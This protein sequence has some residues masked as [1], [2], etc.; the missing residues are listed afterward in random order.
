MNS[1]GRL[2]SLSIANGQLPSVSGSPISFGD[3]LFIYNEAAGASLFSSLLGGIGAASQ[4][5]DLVMEPWDYFWNTALIAASGGGVTYESGSGDY[6][7]WLE[8]ADPDD[9]LTFGDV[10]GVRGGKIS[11]QTEGADQVMVVSY[12][13]IVLGNMPPP[14]EAARYEKVAFMGQVPVKVTGRVAIGDYLVPTGNGDGIARAISPDQ[15]SVEDLSRVIGVAWS[16]T[17]WARLTFVKAAVG[18]QTKQ[19]AKVV[20]AQDERIETLEAQ[21]QNVLQRLDE[22]TRLVKGPTPTEN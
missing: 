6:A 4:Q 15:I 18:L 22:V 20:A 3:P 19:V 14:G 7:E 17:A 9:V 13:P 1:T 21:L 8:R 16:E 2:P 5:V 10:V 12:K 11:K